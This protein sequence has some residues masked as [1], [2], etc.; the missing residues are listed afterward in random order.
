MQCIKFVYITSKMFSY[1]TSEHAES[2][3]LGIYVVIYV[4]YAMMQVLGYLGQCFAS[5]YDVDAEDL[6]AC[7]ERQQVLRQ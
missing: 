1:K 5:W 3:W 2:E 7:V 4:V 6:G